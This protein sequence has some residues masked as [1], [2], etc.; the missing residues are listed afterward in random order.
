[1][2]DSSSTTEQKKEQEQEGDD[3]QDQELGWYHDGVKRTLTDEQ[4]AMFRHS[5]I[6]R[7][8]QQRK[9][10]AELADGR[11]VA[12]VKEGPKRT[13]QTKGELKKTTMQR[14]CGVTVESHLA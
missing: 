5:E 1:M 14:T 12:V 3:D 10:S 11:L 9:L 6:H 8:S 4:I 7:L 2:P 13:K